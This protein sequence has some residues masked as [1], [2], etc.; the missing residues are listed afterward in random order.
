MGGHVLNQ[1]HMMESFLGK[2]SKNSTYAAHASRKKIR[3]CHTERVTQNAPTQ[4][5]FT[6]WKKETKCWYNSTEIYKKEKRK[7][8]IHLGYP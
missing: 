3:R 1:A 7:T 2:M 8:T 6:H 4:N 5:D